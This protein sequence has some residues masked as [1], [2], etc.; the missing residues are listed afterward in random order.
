MTTHHH[1]METHTLR[2]CNQPS[3]L[4]TTDTNGF[5][6]FEIPGHLR[7]RDCYIHVISGSVGDLDAIFEDAENPDLAI[8]RHNIVTNSYDSTSKGTN[9]SFGTVV[10]PAATEKIGALN[11]AQSLD[12][13]R[14]R[15]PPLLEVETVGFISATGAEV[16]LDK[17]K[18]FVEVILMLEFPIER[19]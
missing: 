5:F 17:A 15:L 13:G 1:S 2:I 9:R 3:G 10:R 14:C 7:D 11:E 12:L 16:R 18:G 19:E 8:I 6:A 4:L